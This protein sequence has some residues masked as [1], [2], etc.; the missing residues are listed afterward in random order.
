MEVDSKTQ[1]DSHAAAILAGD[2]QHMFERTD[3]LFAAL[4]VFQW[5]AVIVAALWISPRASPAQSYEQIWM[6]ICQGG[7]ITL[8]P[9]VMVFA[10][11]GRAITRH[12]IAAAQMLMSGLLI[13]LTGGRIE[14]HFHIFGALAFL[15]FYRDWRVL[16]TASIV[17]SADY[18]LGGIFWPQAIIWC[19]RS[20]TVALAGTHRL[21]SVHRRFSY[22][23]YRAEPARDGGDCRTTG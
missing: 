15:S 3:R 14:T 9:L 1:L 20:R 16:V 13:D 19:V 21:G 22:H 2:Q 6:A 11:P 8:L 4:M 18:F 10:L 12:V 7:A 17:T 23:F 5:I